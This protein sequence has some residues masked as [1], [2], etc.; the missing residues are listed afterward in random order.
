MWEAYKLNP[1]AFS[2]KDVLASLPSMPS[3]PFLEQFFQLNIASE[4]ANLANI[5]LLHIHGDNDMIV[6]AE[7]SEAYKQARGANDRSRFIQL[8]NSDH[9]FIDS[10]DKCVAVAETCQWFKQTL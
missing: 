6:K 9:D 10:K 4:L 1:S 5:P 3:L 8:P 2:S 7:H